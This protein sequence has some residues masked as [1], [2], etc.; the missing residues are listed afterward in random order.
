MTRLEF[1]LLRRAYRTARRNL[2]T[3]VTAFDEATAAFREARR[4]TGTWEP[5]QQP[6]S[7]GLLMAEARPLFVRGHWYY[8][9]NVR[10]ATTNFLSRI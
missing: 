9:L 4:L 2:L 7:R 1:T 10:R 5:F 3:S 8:R 6:A